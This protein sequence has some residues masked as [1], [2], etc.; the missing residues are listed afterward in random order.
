MKTR[1]GKYEEASVDT[2]L[3]ERLVYTCAS[4]D[5][6]RYISVDNTVPARFVYG[7]QM[8]FGKNG[9]CNFSRLLLSLLRWTSVSAAKII[10][11]GVIEVIVPD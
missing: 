9:I 5:T 3:P 1:E 11:G 4:V 8:I 7:L 2:P 10:E 6:L